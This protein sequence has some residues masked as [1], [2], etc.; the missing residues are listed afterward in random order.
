MANPGYLFY[1][2]YYNVDRNSVKVNE[3]VQ[4]QLLK[5]TLQTQNNSLFE[6]K[7]GHSFTLKTTYPGLLIGSGYNH[8]ISDCESQL[9]LGFFFDHTT[10]LPLIPGSSIKGLIRSVF[11]SKYDTDKK[12][13][14]KN[15]SSEKEDYIRCIL[16][17]DIDATQLELAIFCGVKNINANNEEDRYFPMSH[18]DI[19]CDAYI[20]NGGKGRQIFGDDYIT[21]HK[22][23]HNRKLDEFANPNPIRFLKILA[24]V[25]FKFQFI[26]K[27]S[28]IDGITISASEKLHLFKTILLDMGIGAKTNVGYG[29]FTE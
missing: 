10:G 18:R 24:N 12:P 27:D 3:K 6:V 4:E 9:K 28:V 11:P 22:N 19:F 23:N 25:T 1:R 2:Q 29:Q 20:S 26:L 8:E 13:V 5:Y 7:N 16:N 14:L 17:K 15:E 21:P